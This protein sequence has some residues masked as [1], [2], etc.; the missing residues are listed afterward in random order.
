MES[1][2][3]TKVSRFEIK[4][5]Q[6]LEEIEA[7]KKEDRLSEILVPIDQMFPSYPKITVKDDWKAFAKNG[8][9]LDH[10]MSGKRKIFGRSESGIC[11]MNQVNSLLFISG[12][13]KKYHIVKMFFSKRGKKDYAVYQRACGI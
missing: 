8:N 9:P 4:D 2:T 3:R 12:K 11:M 13:K 7:L 5:S 10:K 6:T 1:L